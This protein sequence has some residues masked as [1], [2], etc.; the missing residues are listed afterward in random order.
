MRIL[1]AIL[2]ALAFVPLAGAFDIEG[3]RWPRPTVRVWNAT[4]YKQP[5]AD[6]MRA[7]NGAGVRIRLVAA[8]SAA[9]T[10]VL[11]R[12]GSIRE[13]GESTVGFTTDVSTTSLARGLGRI[14]A[15]A[16]AA[17]ELGH[18]L[19]LGHQSGRCAVMAP[20]VNAGPASRCGIGSCKELWRCLVRADD[21]AGVRALY[22]RR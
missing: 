16:L 3:E 13:Q 11:I 10:D 19:G 6:A 20:V 17:H 22:G 2:G 9:D 21:I 7:W 18:V 1:L 14:A 15:T 8:T 5:V 12:Y 4:T